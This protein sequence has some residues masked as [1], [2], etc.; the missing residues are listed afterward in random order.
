[1]IVAFDGSSTDLSI[2]LAEPAGEVLVEEGWTSGQRQS[3]ELLP[4]LLALIEAHGVTLAGATAIAVGTGPGSFTGLRVSM[5][6][7]KG[8]A[9]G[10]GRPIVGV[11]SLEAW[12]DAEPGAEAAVARAGARDAYVLLRGAE[13]PLVADRDRLVER[14]G[15]RLVV[16]PT[17]LSEAFGLRAARSPH[18]AGTIARRAAERLEGEPAGDDL[19]SLEPRYLRAPR[20]VDEPAAGAVRWL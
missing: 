10:L 2:A 3:A 13:D 6:L 9:Y 1:M 14:L 15:D 16:A 11:P 7:A 20:G 12:L 8:L 4:R 18:S 5:A 17:E 19:G